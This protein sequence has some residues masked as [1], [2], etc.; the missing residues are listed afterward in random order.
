MNVRGF[1]SGALVL[2]LGACGAGMPPSEAH[3]LLGTV[4]DRRAEVTLDGAA[5]GFPEEGHVTV[6]EVWATWCKP[7]SGSMRAMQ[8]LWE[9]E[10]ASGVHVIGVAADDNPGLVFRAVRGNGVTFP[11]VIDATGD[12]R[13]WLLVRDVPSAVVFDRHG[14]VRWAKTGFAEGD[15]VA[16]RRAVRDLSE[17]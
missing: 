11:N 2:V 9:A 6:V 4:P 17:E 14:R 3:P 8:E 15:A 12:V 1:G 16:L 10:H 5:I 7:C 13:G